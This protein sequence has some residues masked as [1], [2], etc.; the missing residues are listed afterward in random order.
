VLTELIHD[1]SHVAALGA[2]IT[3]LAI[4]IDPFSQQI[5]HPAICHEILQ[6]VVANV[7]RANNLTGVGNLPTRFEPMSL[8]ADATA[9]ILIGLLKVPETIPVQCSTG[10]CTFSSDA[11]SGAT[12]QT[13]AFESACVDVSAEIE[14]EGTSPPK[15]YIPAIDAGV[16]RTDN[17][18][19]RPDWNSPA[20][21]MVNGSGTFL[22]SYWSSKHV[23]SSL[24]GF[25]AILEPSLF[26]N[27]TVP[28]AVECRMWPVIQT[29]K[30]QIEISELQETVLFSE[31]LQEHYNPK[32]YMTEYDWLAISSKV[33]R[34]GEWEM[35]D[36]SPSFTPKTSV[37][38]ANNT[39]VDVLD[40]ETTPDMQWYADDCVWY[41]GSESVAALGSTLAKMFHKKFIGKGN[42]GRI[43]NGELWIRK[44]WHNGTATLS[45]AE[46]YTAQLAR[47]LTVHTRERAASLNP[48]L[49]NAHGLAFK[50]ETCIQ[51][52]WGW[53]SFPAS[54]VLLTIVFL[55]ATIVKTQKSDH[56]T[57]RHG[58]W[59][60]SSLAILFGGLEDELRHGTRMLEK[61]SD[62][63]QG[64]S[65]LK[66]SLSPGDD[67]WRLR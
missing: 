19:Y 51:V 27:R 17:I 8:D 48:D 26:E 56:L 65:L 36:P 44:L 63:D 43:T 49:G 24:F 39:L 59:K 16:A 37:S 41:I 29:V 28:L 32:S 52:R 13:L 11:A 42:D 60:S 15:W 7:P 50:T 25:A 58:N 20:L 66:V 5:I 2:W 1:L 45:T 4:A 23:N 46:A 57:R 35:C 6:G 3:V 14:Q 21:T 47:A 67:G 64:A 10:N 53:I 38:I 54:L 22:P 40:R 34:N 61:R 62:M 9:A 30:S 31:S 55:A 18:T 33:L 12:Y